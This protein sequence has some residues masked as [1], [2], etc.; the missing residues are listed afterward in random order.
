[1]S[2]GEAAA[3][4]QLSLDLLAAEE[5]LEAVRARWVSCRDA[6][7]DCRRAPPAGMTSLRV[8]QSWESRADALAGIYKTVEAAVIR[9]QAEARAGAGDDAFERSG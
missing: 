2:S 4:L 1:M 8:I 9:L 7:D 5:L 6:A 3:H